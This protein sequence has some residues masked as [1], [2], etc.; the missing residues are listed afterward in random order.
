MDYSVNLCAMG[1]VSDTL[2]H[3]QPGAVLSDLL[4]AVK[5]PSRA[6]HMGTLCQCRT[7]WQALGPTPLVKLCNGRTVKSCKS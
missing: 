4:C 7:T 5:M 6:P 3:S 1:A 2:Q